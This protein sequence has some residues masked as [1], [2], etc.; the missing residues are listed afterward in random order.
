MAGGLT[1]ATKI[2]SDFMNTIGVN[3]NELVTPCSLWQ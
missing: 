1:A 3:N 2:Q